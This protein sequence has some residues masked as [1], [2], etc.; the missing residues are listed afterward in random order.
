MRTSVRR[1]R[2]A[3]TFIGGT[4]RPDH[5][6]PGLGWLLNRD[7]RIP[8]PAARYTS[9]QFLNAVA[10]VSRSSSAS[11]RIPREDV[12][13]LSPECSSSHRLRSSRARVSPKRSGFTGSEA[14]VNPPGWRHKPRD[15]CGGTYAYRRRRRQ[16]R[17]HTAA[18]PASRNQ[19]RLRLH[20]SARFAWRLRRLLPTLG[21]LRLARHD[22]R[23]HIVVDGIGVHDHLGDVVAA[24]DVEHRQLQ[25]LLHDGA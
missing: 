5:S 2:R 3:Q 16:S 15:I 17:Q 9:S 22:C 1:I 7:P 14:V 11:L 18:Y 21:A 10:A 8:K 24:W 25:D 20:S 23:Q 6:G 4:S 19:P 13:Q 12:Y